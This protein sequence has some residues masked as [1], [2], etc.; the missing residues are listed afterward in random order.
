MGTRSQTPASKASQRNTPPL[1]TLRDEATANGASHKQMTSSNEN[2]V[3]P[4]STQIAAEAGMQSQK[5]ILDKLPRAELSQISVEDEAMP[6]SPLSS[7]TGSMKE[8][9]D[10]YFNWSSHESPSTPSSHDEI[11]VSATESV[12]NPSGSWGDTEVPNDVVSRP[13]S[14]RDEQREVAISKVVPNSASNARSLVQI[15]HFDAVVESDGR[16]DGS[17]LQS[18][19]CHDPKPRDVEATSN[20]PDNRESTTEASTTIPHGVTKSDESFEIAT[21]DVGNLATSLKQPPGASSSPKDVSASNSTESYTRLRKRSISSADELAISDPPVKAKSSRIIAQTHRKTKSKSLSSSSRDD[22]ASKRDE[23]AGSVDNVENV[24]GEPLRRSKRAKTGGNTFI[25]FDPDDVELPYDEA[26]ESEIEAWEGW[27]EMESSPETLTVMMQEWGVGGMKAI[28][29]WS[30]EPE[31]LVVLPQPVHGLIFCYPYRDGDWS[32]QMD[33]CPDHVWFANQVDG[34]NACGTVALMNIINNVSNA[35]LGPAL[36]SFRSETQAMSAV[37]RGDYLNNFRPIKAV[38]N[39][40]IHIT[41]MME[42][43]LAAEKDYAAWAKKADLEAKKRIK[44]SLAAKRKKAAEKEARRQQRVAVRAARQASS[45]ELS[46]EGARGSSMSISKL[47]GGTARPGV[48]TTKKAPTKKAN[49]ANTKKKMVAPQ[50]PKKETPAMA[51]AAAKKKA[52]ALAKARHHYVAYLP[53]NGELWK[54]DGMDDQ[55]LNLGPCDHATWIHAVAPLIQSSMRDLD[56]ES[57]TF[58]LLAVVQDPLYNDVIDLA[59]NIKTMRQVDENLAAVDPDW[60]LHEDAGDCLAD[61]SL[62]GPSDDYNVTDDMI[63]EA[64]ISVGSLEDLQTS[65]S[66]GSL[67]QMKKSLISQQKMLKSSIRSGKAEGDRRQAQVNLRRRD[68]GPLIQWQLMDLIDEGVLDELL[69]LHDP[70]KKNGAGASGSI[71]KC[72]GKAK[73]KGKGRKR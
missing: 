38:H 58:S 23:D 12:G 40:F 56:E 50:K 35:Q 59:A 19:L 22:L 26:T 53:I 52:D 31:H 18:R 47:A 65:K 64:K 34:T 43:D 15:P 4:T 7:P 25:E 62:E 69:D 6:E 55:P 1:P 45:G 5:P 66:V 33:P 60:P 14:P 13:E 37:E 48:A 11:E 9:L 28:D 44:A 72:N 27:L 8:A 32:E 17:L 46:P 61:E 41:E 54:L 57:N 63:G 49:V 67:L 10:E 3:P 24:K 42:D 73:P 2:E 68:F 71:K 16:N 30:L 29:V 20:R 51:K 70:K 21:S 36:R 39:S